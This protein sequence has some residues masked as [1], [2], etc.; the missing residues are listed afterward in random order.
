MLARILHILN[1]HS[2]SVGNLCL[3]ISPC[4]E[5]FFI[6][7]IDYSVCLYTNFVKWKNHNIQLHLHILLPDRLN[8]ILSANPVQRVS[9]NCPQ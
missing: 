2:P 9:H 4:P 1:L 6:Q 5:E 3:C 8:N 7:L